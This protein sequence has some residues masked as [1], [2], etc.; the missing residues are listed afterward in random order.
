MKKTILSLAIALISLGGL[1]A[2]AQTVSTQTTCKTEQC[3]GKN[4]KQKKEC[5]GDKDG[6]RKGCKKEKGKCTAR[7]GR[8]GNKKMKGNPAMQ[9]I[10][11]T[12][13]QQ[14]KVDKIRDDAKKDLA[15]IKEDSKKDRQKV[16]SKVDSEISKVLT[17][18]Q[19]VQFEANQ[20]AIQARKAARM[21]G[22]KLKA[23][24]NKDI[25]AMRGDVKKMRHDGERRMQRI[26][27]SAKAV[28]KE[29]KAALK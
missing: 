10:T 11:L 8:R 17:A 25:S 19:R 3:Q 7:D 21:E 16:M 6:D 29:V 23:K 18:E 13:E 26:D 24:G 15:K 20:K 9:G 1:S 14:Q 28:K 27:A 2:A 5:K 12:A 4:D 22:D